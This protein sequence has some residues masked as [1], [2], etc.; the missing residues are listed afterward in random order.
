MVSHTNTIRQT[1]FALIKLT[2]YK[3]AE[4]YNARRA[5]GGWAAHDMDVTVIR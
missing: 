4:I 5:W 1:R 2:T 3:M